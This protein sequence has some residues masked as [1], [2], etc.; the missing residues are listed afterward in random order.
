MTTLS[1]SPPPVPP[2]AQP[3]LTMRPPFPTIGQAVLLALMLLGAQ[4]VAG[5]LLAGIGL[6]AEKSVFGAMGPGAMSVAN[7]LS[8]AVVFGIGIAW[9]K[10]PIRQA[11]PLRPIRMMLL[12]PLVVTIVGLSALLSDLSNLV[13]FLL[14]PPRFAN[15]ILEGL[16][17]S[18][19]QVWQSVVLLS[20]VAPFTEEPLFRGLMLNG[21]LGSR[22]P[23]VAVVITAVLFAAVHLNPWQLL[24]ALVLGLL[25]GWWFVRTRSLWPGIVGHAINNSLGFI[26]SCIPGFEIPGY[27]SSIS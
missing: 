18:E 4:A 7:V 5:F 25:F 20:L 19:G 8:F 9:G 6:L 23:W 22:R 15:E 14:P 1:P 16:L 12:L 17:G 2:I 21:M 27:T 13:L 24:P 10:L 3:V 11:L 26:I